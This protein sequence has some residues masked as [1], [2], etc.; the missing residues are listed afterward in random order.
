MLS[1]KHH[2]SSTVHKP[3]YNNNNSNHTTQKATNTMSNNPQRPTRMS[4]GPPRRSLAQAMSQQVPQIS[5]VDE[6]DAT[7][8][9][10]T[11]SDATAQA[12]ASSSSSETNNI[13]GLSKLQN[14]LVQGTKSLVFLSLFLG[15]VGFACAA[16]V[17][18][19][20]DE[21][22]LFRNQVRLEF[23]GCWLPSLSTRV[24]LCL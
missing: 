17:F 20:S 8:A 11:K 12:P 16:Y 4:N 1:N 5:D 7:A 22:S 2:Q 10:S 14:Q 3:H 23:W 13:T 19:R 15:A 21:T 9:S 24:L 18:A 6:E